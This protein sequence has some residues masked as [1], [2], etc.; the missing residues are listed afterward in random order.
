MGCVG[1]S[2]TTGPGLVGNCR[3]PTS[4]ELLCNGDGLCWSWG[5]SDVDHDKGQGGAS[6]APWTPPRPPVSV[7]LQDHLLWCFG[8]RLQAHSWW[9]GCASAQRHHQAGTR[10][11]SSTPAKSQPVLAA[12]RERCSE[13]AQVLGRERPLPRR[14]HDRLGT[15]CTHPDPPTDPQNRLLPSSKGVWLPPS[16]CVLRYES[17]HKRLAHAC[18]VDRASSATRTG[19]VWACWHRI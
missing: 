12:E 10:Q 2:P 1:H 19:K 13:E 9:R 15:H 8:P 3:T 5:L 11:P 16:R 7:E 6:G 14:G 17:V 4:L 18:C